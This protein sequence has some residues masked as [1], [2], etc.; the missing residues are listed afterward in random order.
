LAG[1]RETARQ[2]AQACAACQDGLGAL[3]VTNLSRTP[4]RLKP[5]G[6]TL[7]RQ[8]GRSLDIER[9]EGLWRVAEYWHGLLV[10]DMAE[11]IRQPLRRENLA[12]SKR[13]AEL[14]AEHQELRE[15]AD[16]L[17][18]RLRRSQVERERAMDTIAR[19]EKVSQAHEKLVADSN[20]LE[21]ELASYRRD[22]AQALD[23]IGQLEKE[24]VRAEVLAHKLDHESRLSQALRQ[25]SLERHQLYRQSEKQRL[26]LAGWQEEANQRAKKLAAT[27]RRLAWTK[28]ELDRLRLERVEAL[29][30]AGLLENLPEAGQSMAERR[31]RPAGVGS[32]LSAELSAARQEAWRWSRLAGDLSAALAV[33]SSQHRGQTKELTQEVYELRHEAS[34][35]QQELDTLRVL[36][37]AALSFQADRLPK[38]DGLTLSPEQVERLL[39][40]LAVARRKLA[41]LGRSTVGQL[42][43]IA[44]LTAGLVLGNPQ[45]PSKATLLEANP[46][47]ERPALYQTVHTGRMELAQDA[48]LTMS[49]VGMPLHRLM[50]R[51]DLKV[52]LAPQRYESEKPPAEVARRVTRVAVR[53][54]VDPTVLMPIAG[55]ACQQQA[56]LE[57]AAL[58][59]IAATARGLADNHPV[60]KHELEQ[61]G[62]WPRDLEQTTRN[63][64]RGRY[65]DKLYTEYRT[66]GFSP[67]QALGALAAAEEATLS[68]K[69][70]WKSPNKFKGKVRPLET[71]EEMDLATFVR[72]MAP[73]IA[74]RAGRFLRSRGA[75]F[76]GDMAEYSREL[77]HDMYCA[78]DKFDL[79][80]SVLFAIAHQETWYANVLGDQNRSASP[81]HIFNPT[82]LLILDSMARAGYL[83]PPRTISL[84]RHLT[85]ATYMAAFHLRE[86]MQESWVPSGKGG[87]Y[88][89]MNQVMKRY[90]GSSAYAGRVAKRQREQVAYLKKIRP[91]KSLAS[92]DLT[93][94]ISIPN[95]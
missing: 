50:G 13:L 52:D 71:M 40:R 26:E 9:L 73:F 38:P 61:R 27:E 63:S 39:K 78:A 53:E 6:N 89:D 36:L 57:S 51:A 46:R 90:N 87:G 75:D 69:Q 43:L 24:A 49:A 19:L 72:R 80:V 37:V 60:I 32:S 91:N 58:Q 77:A 17:D 2:T 41:D 55:L 81:F 35:L 56:P 84:E 83:P 42:S 74:D 47:L 31:A 76:T 34:E 64:R 92:Q 67:Q 5:Y 79:P 21:Q 45:P 82:K 25:K 94:R 68:L 16:R 8:R 66:L 22:H 95:L 54:G 33:L 15:H 86:L 59:R 3:L 30:E 48:P 4:A 85:M 12:L 1:R 23:T 28:A 88:V 29:G 70:Q 14:D 93:A 65:L 20:R 18:N 11:R 7:R 62:E 10:G 44:A